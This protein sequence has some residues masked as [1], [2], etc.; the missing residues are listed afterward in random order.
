MKY[1]ETLMWKEINET[2]EIF[3]EIQ[4][5]NAKIMKDL[6]ADIK[7]GMQQ[8]SLLQRAERVTTL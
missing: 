1:N 7:A 4:S 2:T 5:N 3:G 8:T 6:V